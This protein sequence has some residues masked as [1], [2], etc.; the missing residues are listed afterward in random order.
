M[1][2]LQVITS[3]VHQ[4]YTP[5][6]ICQLELPHVLELRRQRKAIANGG[7]G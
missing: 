2:I 5:H 3:A 1:A 7:P 4:S 6:H